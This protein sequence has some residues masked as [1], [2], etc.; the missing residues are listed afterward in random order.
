M[1]SDT[2]ADSLESED[3]T[4]PLTEADSKE[5]GLATITNMPMKSTPD[6]SGKRD[7][8]QATLGESI[9][10]RSPT[11]ISFVLDFLANRFRLRAKGR[12]SRTLV[13]RFSSR[14]AE[15]RNLKDLHCYSSRMLKA[16]LTMTK[17]ELS[18]SSFNRWMNWGTGS[19]GKFLTANISESH[20]IGKE[21]SL[22]DILE[23]EVP[24]RYFLSKKFTK[25]VL[26]E[27]KD[28]R[29]GKLVL[30]SHEE[31]QEDTTPEGT[32]S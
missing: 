2:E 7:I 6:T 3:S 8:I 5:P 30:P 32:M 14:Y 23:E 11:S 31:A 13:E 10:K 21:C 22:S 9:Q 26:K 1:P 12:V 18:R 4:L 25:T 27:L 19:N 17:E 15:L 24:D 29:G 16:S 20:R 28:N